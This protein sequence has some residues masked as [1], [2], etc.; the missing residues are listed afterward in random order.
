MTILLLL[1]IQA[2]AGPQATAARRGCT[3]STPDEVVVCARTG[4]SPYRLRPIPDADRFE[5]P[6][7][8]GMPPAAVAAF[9]GTLSAEGESAMLAGG[10]V[11]KRAMVR[12]T[13][14]F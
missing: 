2:A 12:F 10:Q 3:P 13:K 1:A 5:R 11:S 8:D 14:P 4:E 7:R 9:G 6:R